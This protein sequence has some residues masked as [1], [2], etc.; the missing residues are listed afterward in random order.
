[1][2]DA[3][4]DSELRDDGVVGNYLVLYFYDQNFKF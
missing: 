2:F 4:F 3:S 1:M